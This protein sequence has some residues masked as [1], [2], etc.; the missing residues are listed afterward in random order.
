S[1]WWDVLGVRQAVVN[2]VTNAVQAIEGGGG[3]GRVCVRAAPEPDDR[4]RVSVEDDGPGIPPDVRARMFEP[5]VTTRPRGVGLG[6]TVVR[7]A[8]DDHAGDLFVTSRPG[9]GTRVD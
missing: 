7:R 2:L 3:R 4:I 5:F 1:A 6:L 9:E 8:V